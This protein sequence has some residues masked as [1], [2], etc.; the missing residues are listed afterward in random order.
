MEGR[1]A[2]FVHNIGIE[3]FAMVVFEEE[4]GDDTL[5][6]LGC[7]VERCQLVF[8]WH[9][10]ISVELFFEDLKNLQVTKVTC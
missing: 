4:D 5:F 9:S 1:G 8:C 3:V 6:S 2:V 7:A 10:K